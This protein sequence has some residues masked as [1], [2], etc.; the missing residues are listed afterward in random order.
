VISS[1]CERQEFTDID[2]LRFLSVT[3]I[4]TTNS[5]AGFI[6]IYE[7]EDP[8]ISGDGL[9]LK[10]RFRLP[11]LAVGCSYNFMNTSCYPVADNTWHS[12]S[13][14]PSLQESLFRPSPDDL[15]CAIYIP[16][17]QLGGPTLSHTL[18]IHIRVFI[19]L[20]PIVSTF[21]EEQ[22]DIPVPWSVW[23]PQNT[24]WCRGDLITIGYASYG[25]KVID[26][27]DSIDDVTGTMG[28]R[29]RLRDFNP[30]AF[31]PSKSDVELGDRPRG[32]V[33]TEPFRFPAG[34]IFAEEV[35]SRLPYREVISEECFRNFTEVMMDGNQIVLLKVTY[36]I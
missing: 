34:E 10:G 30:Y 13:P 3:T 15:I 36:Y 2:D 32:K 19:G 1:Q 7:F 5:S 22:R 16:V 33:I 25:L 29:L 20:D 24:R 23:G 9:K 21:L 14:I 18:F 27:F 17:Q 6:G 26:S 8:A 28:A 4:L 11:S 12:R 31:P 35:E